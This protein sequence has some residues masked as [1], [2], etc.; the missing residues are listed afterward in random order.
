MIRAVV[1]DVGGVVLSWRRDAPRLD[2][3]L[4]DELGLERGAVGRLLWSSPQLRDAECG[5]ISAAE[6][7][8]F[9]CDALGA[10]P[11]VLA[12]FNEALW[13]ETQYLDERIVAWLTQLRSRC[14]V[15]AFTNAWSDARDE[16]NRRYQFDGL[17]DE[18]VVSAELGLAKP[19]PAAYVRLLGSLLLPAE[20]VL[21]VDDRP[22]NV[23]AAVGVGM[24]GLVCT[25]PDQLMES[26]DS[27][28]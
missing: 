13:S 15:V 19:D 5:R 4:E 22:A 10:P 17:V 11:D 21:F 20:Q 2:E 7:W 6:F 28:L 25:G 27:L 1:L 12:R 8:S 14:R 9:G 16:L 23:E 26:V 24:I 3:S 18:L